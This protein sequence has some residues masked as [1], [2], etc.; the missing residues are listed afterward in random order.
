MSPVGGGVGDG[1]EESRSQA[2]G[3]WKRPCAN[4]E[5]PWGRRCAGGG[6]PNTVLSNPIPPPYPF[7]GAVG[8][9]KDRLLGALR[10]FQRRYM[11]PIEAFA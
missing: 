4:P 1:G 2:C 5:R 10:R 7:L 11:R 8:L 9:P 6:Y 3:G